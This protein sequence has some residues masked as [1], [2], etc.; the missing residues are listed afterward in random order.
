M[1]AKSIY[2]A[3]PYSNVDKEES[4][5]IVN[6]IA[7]KLMLQGYIVFSP[8]SM[9]HAIACENQLPTDFEFWGRMCEF[10]VG[11]CDETWIVC[12]EGHIKSVGVQAEK[13]RSIKVEYLDIEGEKLGK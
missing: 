12:M 6:K 5:K 7:A 13:K 2:L 9:G 4:F 8:I 1:K 11:A 10:F 3:I